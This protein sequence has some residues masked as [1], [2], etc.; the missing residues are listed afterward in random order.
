[1]LK[2]PRGGDRVPAGAWIDNC[3][4]YEI[5]RISEQSL[6]LG[7]YPFTTVGRLRHDSI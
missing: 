7:C 4:R 1:M 3:Y 5:D 2:F 6:K